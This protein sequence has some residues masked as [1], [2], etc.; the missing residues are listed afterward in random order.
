MTDSPS[1]QPSPQRG[2]GAWQALRH[3]TARLTSITDTPRLDAELL[4]A[5]ALGITRERLILDPPDHVPESF[6]TL[7]QRRL[8]REPLAYIT[9]SRDFWTITLAVGPGVLIPRPDS[10]CL[11]EAALDHF[12]AAPPATILDLG[13]G[14]G[15]LLL[16]A[17]SEFPDAQGV[18]VDASEVALSYARRNAAALGLDDRT[19]V[20][21]GDWADG[22]EGPFE[23]ILCNPPYVESDAALSPEVMNEP[24]SALFAGPDG[25]DDY[26][27]LAPQIAA[28]LAP[29]GCACVEIGFTQADTVSAMF[30]ALGLCVVVRKDLGGRDRCLL[31]TR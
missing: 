31:V 10:E 14:P 21:L 19:N 3:A 26:R 24:H 11:I 16:A 15:T 7:L 29:G 27:R 20:R 9:G 6:D 4:L 8:A 25:L 17:M 22:L 28:L 12:A 1:P 23:L 5:H 2:V 13:T 30:Q 18:G